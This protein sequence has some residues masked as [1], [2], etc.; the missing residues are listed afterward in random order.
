MKTILLGT[1]EIRVTD[2][3]KVTGTIQLVFTWVYSIVD[4]WREGKNQ[5]VNTQDSS[6]HSE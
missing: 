5:P 6:S 1:Q 3:M 2:V 4:A